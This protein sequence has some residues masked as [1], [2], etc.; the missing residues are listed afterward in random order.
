MVHD[1]RA[2]ATTGNAVVRCRSQAGGGWIGWISTIY[3]DRRRTGD[4]RCNRI[5][6]GDQLVT[7][8]GI[9]GS[10]GGLVETVDGTGTAQAT[11]STIVGIRN[12]SWE[13]TRTVVGHSYAVHI[14]GWNLCVTR[15]GEVTGADDYW[16]Y[17]ILYG[18]D[19]ITGAYVVIVVGHG[20]GH[21]VGTGVCTVEVVRRHTQAGNSASVIGTVVHILRRDAG[22]TVGIELDGDVLTQCDRIDIV[23]NGH[24]C[25]ATALVV[26]DIGHRQGDGIATAYVV[27]IKAGIVKYEAGNSTSIVGA[28]VDILRCGAACAI[29]IQLDGYILA[30]G[31]R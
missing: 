1:R 29:G 5:N 8:R 12:M 6:Y 9:A 16:C 19:G 27:T 13:C 31:D 26:V 11:Q 17:R 28:V 30:K 25:G 22:S 15:N 2:S 3:R 4:D 23:F 7:G 24:G 14:H 18:Y 20:E 10:I 21:G